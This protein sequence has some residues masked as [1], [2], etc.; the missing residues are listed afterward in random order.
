LATAK[1]LE[2]GAAGRGDWEVRL[3]E[4]TGGGKAGRPREPPPPPTGKRGR[5]RLGALLT[6]ADGLPLKGRGF[7]WTRRPYE[8]SELQLLA[9]ALA[10]GLEQVHDQLGIDVENGDD[11]EALRREIG[12]LKA[13]NNKIANLLDESAAYTQKLERAL[14]RGEHR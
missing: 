7:V 10:T 6:D 3:Q 5:P 1:Q 13:R 9:E 12:K 2:E 8:Q 14:A 4:F 11:V